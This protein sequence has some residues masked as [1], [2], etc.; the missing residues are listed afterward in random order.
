MSEIVISSSSNNIDNA[1]DKYRDTTSYCSSS[2]GSSTSSNRG[3]TTDEEYTSGVPGVP[4]E[5]LQEQLRT[6]A[7]SKS[8]AGTSIAH[9][10]ILHDEVETMYSCAVGGHSKTDEKRLVFFRSWY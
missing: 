5:V 9:L 1:I 2:N 8:R 6:R 3:N 7:A 10:S 4:L